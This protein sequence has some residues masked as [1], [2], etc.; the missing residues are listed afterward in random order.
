MAKAAGPKPTPMISWI[1][2]C[3]VDRSRAGSFAALYQHLSN[4]SVDSISRVPMLF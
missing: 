3:A 2:S 4:L 1:A